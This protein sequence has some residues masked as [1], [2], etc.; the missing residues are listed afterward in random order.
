[1]MNEWGSL[2]GAML[3]AEG[4]A[5]GV[6]ANTVLAAAPTID[7]G[8]IPAA[9]LWWDGF[10]IAKNISDEDAEASFQRHGARHQPGASPPRTPASPPG[11]S[12]ATSPARPRSA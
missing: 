12:R 1:M 3:D 9:A 7:G 4:A 5:D 10:T 8:T 11:W 2:A 6:V